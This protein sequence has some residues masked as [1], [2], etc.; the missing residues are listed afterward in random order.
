MKVY[1]FPKLSFASLKGFETYLFN[2]S[3]ITKLD[4]I[5]RLDSREHLL[6]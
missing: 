4:K 1:A 3:K 2:N 6:L 5:L